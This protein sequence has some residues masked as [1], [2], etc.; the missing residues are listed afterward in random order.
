M[1]EG[2]SA[3]LLGRFRECE[4]LDRLLADVRAGHSRALVLRGEAGIGKS[5]LLA[6]AAEQAG[7]ARVLDLHGVQ[8]ETAMPF[9]GLHALLYLVRTYLPSLSEP[10]GQAL[11]AALGIATG[12]VPSRFLVSA[13]VVELLAVLAE[14]RPVVCLVDDA[15]WV[16][17]QSLGALTFA[18]RRL[19]G[20][21]VAMLFALRVEAPAEQSQAA[22][23]LADLP[24]A[25]VGPLDDPSV[26]LWFNPA[27]FVAPPPNTYGDAGR[28]ILYSP[29]HLNFDLSLVKRIFMFNGRV[30]AQVRIE[31]FNLF[32]NPGFGF[33]N[34]AIGSPTVG[35]ITTTVVDNRSMQ[36][37]LKFDF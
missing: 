6:Y 37:A 18:Q 4:A 13:A 23:L 11:S 30:N 21:R 19:R 36:F 25:T 34:A 24:Q 1:P 8:T 3:G 14:E 22:R 32:N 35:R 29:G 33:P 17:P 9:A 7:T 27:D 15:Q 26:D 10:Q 5:T 31:S 16:D 12:E 28:G 2:V 20:D